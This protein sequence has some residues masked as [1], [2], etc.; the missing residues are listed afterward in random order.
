MG[1]AMGSS[2]RSAF[3]GTYSFATGD[4]FCGTVDVTG[5]P[6]GR[7]I[8]HYFNTGECDAG[9]F[10]ARLKQVGVG[11]RYSVNRDAAYKLVDGELS[12]QNL[13]LDEAMRL[14]ELEE[15]PAVRTK[16][17]IPKPTAYDPA[18]H[19]QTKAWYAYRQLSGL[20]LHESPLGPSPYV[21]AWTNDG[22]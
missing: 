12:G 19:N 8:L 1:L 2:G 3:T 22:M 13:D 21:P 17:S 20:S 9:I 18:R 5:R 16:E 6:A 4:L 11:V 7:G 10:D 14:M 15:T